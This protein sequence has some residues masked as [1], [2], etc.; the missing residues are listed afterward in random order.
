MT[1]AFHPNA[2]P[3]PTL[4][5][6]LVPQVGLTSI[7]PRFRPWVDADVSL[8]LLAAAAHDS[9][10]T[11]TAGETDFDALAEPCSPYLDEQRVVWG[12]AGVD[13]LVRS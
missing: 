1:G 4:Q 9:I 13:Q 3:T 10:A 12:N 7:Y 2:T 8:N 5:P 6:L 11:L